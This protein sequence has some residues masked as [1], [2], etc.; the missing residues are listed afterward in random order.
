LGPKEV[1]ADSLYG[2]DVNCEKAKSLG[3]E[4]IS[5]VMGKSPEGSITL[6]DFTTT[7]EGA[8]TACF[9]GHTPDNATENDGKH[10]IVFDTQVCQACPWLNDCAIV[11]G[12]KGSSLCY[13]KKMLRL[14]KRRAWEDTPA[15]KNKYRF[16]SG[17]EGT[18]SQY[19]RKTGVKH[20]RVRGLSA[21]S[22]AA[23]LK[24]VGINILR[25]TAFWN[26]KN[27][28]EQVL[29]TTFSTLLCAVKERLRFT[30]NAFR[31]YCNRQRLSIRFVTYNAS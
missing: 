15:F 17:I 25:A 24:A 16:R 13:T 28:G 10:T 19:D 22:F 18:M 1:L 21:V 11:S 31:Q 26:G 23:V 14:A 27:E 5:P 29:P 30:L 9:A 2:S 20:L 7:N 12:K 6:A 4:V 8:I 3:V